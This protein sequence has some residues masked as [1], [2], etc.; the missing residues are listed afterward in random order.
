MLMRGRWSDWVWW[1]CL[2][3]V[4]GGAGACVAEKKGVTKG[5]EVKPSAVFKADFEGEDLEQ[6]WLGG[7]Q[8]A[9]MER[10][11]LAPDPLQPDN[12]V[13]CLTVKPGDMVAKGA[14][15]EL[16]WNHLD[17]EGSER[18]ISWRVYLPADF[19]MAQSLRDGQGRP[20]W[21]IMGQWH[22]TPKE[23]T[24]A[25]QSPPLSVQLAYLDQSDPGYKRALKDAGSSPGFDKRWDKQPVFFLSYG[26]PPSKA[27]FAAATLGQWNTILIHVRWSQQDDGFVQMWINDIEVTKGKMTGRNMYNDLPNYFKLGLYRNPDLNLT[28]QVCYDDLRYGQTRQDVVTP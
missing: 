6:V 15:A 11:S 22:D 23:G 27:A 18:W 7:Y 10:L 12:Q 13:A 21:Q 20:N 28:Q 4:C 14:R 5:Q 24:P 3:F 25:G 1:G 2:V 8:L 19:P 9:A 26:A 17:P 16:V